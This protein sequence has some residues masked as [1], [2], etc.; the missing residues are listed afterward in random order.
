MIR[1]PRLALAF[2]LSLACQAA[3]AGNAANGARI[4]QM[5]CMACHGIGGKPIMQNAPS[6]SRA[7]RLAQPDFVLA[8]SVKTGK[9]QMPPFLGILKE[10][11]IYDA[12]AYIRTLP[13]SR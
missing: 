5:H 8:N 7:E 6:F 11:D 12:L 1:L 2:G 13:T 9:G 4:Y 3:L 10:Q